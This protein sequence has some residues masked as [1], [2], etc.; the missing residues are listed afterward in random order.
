MRSKA[1]ELRVRSVVLVECFVA[2]LDLG[3]L[4][5][6]HGRPEAVPEDQFVG[7]MQPRTTKRASAFAASAASTRSRLPVS[8]TGGRGASRHVNLATGK[9]GLMAASGFSSAGN[10][11]LVHGA[12]LNT[13]ALSNDCRVIVRPRTR[14]GTRRGG[15]GIAPSTSCRP[16]SSSRRPGDGAAVVASARVNGPDRGGT[17]R[18]AGRSATSQTRPARTTEPDARPSRPPEMVGP[19]LAGGADASPP[20]LAVP[21]PAPT[22]ASSDTLGGGMSGLARKHARRRER[23]ERGGHDRRR[24]PGGSL[25]QLELFARA[26]RGGESSR[27]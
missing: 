12:S 8:A 19:N 18:G 21:R 16:R 17:G 20:D 23:R 5:A 13:H 7:A 26:D 22:L 11:A 1:T 14:A 15:C 2:G 6:M 24:S 10:Q 4:E 25:R 27:L 9:E 3:R